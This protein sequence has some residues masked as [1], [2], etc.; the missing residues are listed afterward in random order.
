MDSCLRVGDETERVA[1]GYSI[2]QI[3]MKLGYWFLVLL[4]ILVITILPSSLLARHYSFSKT[5]AYKSVKPKFSPPDIVFGIVWPI[6]YVLMSLSIWFALRTTMDS[7]S[8][9][10]GLGI[11]II[12][13]YLV[14]LGLNFAW[15]P[16]FYKKDYMRS[17]GILLSLLCVSLVLFALLIKVNVIAGGLWAPYLA[18]L[19]FALQLNVAVVINSQN[20]DQLKSEAM[21]F[22]S[23]T[24]DDLKGR[25]DGLL[26]S[27]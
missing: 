18:W 24:K 19:I 26:S 17:L 20:N 1:V 5:N 6:L 11:T 7:P 22:I 3:K 4:A 16:V 9:T 14:S 8:K 15:V 27:I 25:I 2:Y 23:K 10:H 13:L 21:K 12:V